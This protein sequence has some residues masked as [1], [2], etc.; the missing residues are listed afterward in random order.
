MRGILLAAFLLFSATGCGSDGGGSGADPGGSGGSSGGGPSGG[1]PACDDAFAKVPVP[2]TPNTTIEPWGGFAVDENGAVFT[3]IRSLALTSD[4]GYPITIMSSDLD[5][6]LTTLHTGDDQSIFGNFILHGDSVYMLS[7]VSAPGVARMDRSGGTPVDVVDDFVSAGPILRGDF[8][9]YATGGFANRGIYRLD[10]ETDEST[11]LLTREDAINTLDLDGDTLY[12]IE[13]DGPFEETDYRLF[14]VP[15][16]GGT[17]ELVQALPRAE[18]VLGYFRVIDG[19]VFG[20]GVTED[21]DVVVTRTPVGGAITVVEPSGGEPLVY[22]DGFVYYRSG[23]GSITKAPLSF[24]SKTTIAGS[25]GRSIDS[26]ALGPDDLW[27]SELSC[28]FR[29]AK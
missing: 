10:P 29:T 5:G 28:I 12:W 8:I 9:Y 23:S 19:I 7:G 11:L 14:R 13:S 21:W 1:P 6:H 20:A 3:A 16:A 26:L 4:T 17:P 2:Y 27:Y 24:T 18:A 15:L 25:A 22:G